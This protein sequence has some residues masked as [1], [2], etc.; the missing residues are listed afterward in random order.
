M[1]IVGSLVLIEPISVNWT[2][3]ARCYRWGATSEYQLKISNENCLSVCR[4]HCDKT[5]ERSV[6]IFIPYER[7]YSLVFSERK[8]LVEA[9]PSTW[10]FGSA[11][12]RCNKIT[13]FE[14]IFTCSTSAITPS[15]K[16]SIYTNRKSTKR[17]Q[18]TEDDHHT[19]FLS[20]LLKNGR[21]P[22]KITLRL[23]KVCY[24][25]SLCER[26]QRQSCKAFIGL[27]VQKMTGGGDPFYLKFCRLTTLRV[28]SLIFN[29]FSL[30]APQP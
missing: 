30:V 3:F 9:T 4:V 11:G 23:K 6:Q 20:P 28:K 26:C 17:F 14:L 1:F 8:W 12:P 27:S 5:E 21:F 13:D 2:F 16:S 24:K 15:E 29:L 25:D 7:S 10:N 18:W 22:C 19:L